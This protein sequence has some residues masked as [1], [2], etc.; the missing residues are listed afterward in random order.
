MSHAHPRV[1]RG[2]HRTSR[3]LSAA[4]VPSLL[5][6]LSVAALVTAVYVWRGQETPPERAAAAVSRSSTSSS[7]SGSASSSP[8]STAPSPS[9]TTKRG[10]DPTS[11][12]PAVRESHVVV[13]NQSGRAGLAGRVGDMLRGKGWT[14]DA[15]GNFRGVVPST[16]VYYP[17]GMAAAAAAVAKELP[18]TPRIKPRFA[19]LSTSRLTV[20]VTS[21]YPG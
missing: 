13:L 12:A 16:T 14:V 17:P 7:P 9:T 6:V 1:R 8:S 5:A 19:N 18:S 2:A 15:V 11:S 10:A 20:V 21:S 4:V 3:E